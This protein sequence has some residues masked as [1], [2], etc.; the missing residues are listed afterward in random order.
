M[1]YHQSKDC[2]LVLIPEVRLPINVLMVFER[3]QEGRL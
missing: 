2:P 3:P 1:T